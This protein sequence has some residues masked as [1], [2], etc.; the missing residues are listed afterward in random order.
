MSSSA[1]ALHP[2]NALSASQPPWLDEAAYP[3][4]PRWCDVP[5]GKLH[6]VDE[7]KGEPIVFS[8]GT[9]TWSFEWRHLLRA[10]SPHARVIAPDHLGF[11]LSERPRGADYSPEAHAARFRAFVEALEL[12]RFTL[13]VHDYGGPFALPFAIE[14]PERI[15]RLVVINSW[16]WSF[17]SEPATRGVARLAG[18][19][20][21]RFLYRWLNASLRLVAPSAYGDRKKLTPAIHGQYLAPFRDRWARD[22]VLFALA[23]GLGASKAHQDA[24]W[25]RRDRLAS[26]PSLIV[27]GMRDRALAPPLLDRWQRALPHAKVVRIENAGHW[28]HEEQPDEVIEALRSFV[29]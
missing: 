7:G 27:W 12:P 18:S 14:A 24:L 5:G 22:E 21:M 2:Q 6:Y 23:H 25:E 26:L 15:A 29:L 10:L 19:F 20:V 16:M 9:P 17:D 11:G 13:V 1:L 4:A 28:P 8:H 3:F